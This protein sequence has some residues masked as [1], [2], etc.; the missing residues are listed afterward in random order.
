VSLISLGCAKNLIN[1]EQMLAM[2]SSSGFTITS[3]TYRADIAVINTCGFIEAAKKE[4]IDTILECAELKKKGILRHIIVAGCLAERY[5]DEIRS[6]LPEVDAILGIGN[7]G[8]ITDTIQELLSEKPPEMA[9]TKRTESLLF[10]LSAARKSP[11][12]FN[13]NLPRLVTTPKSWAYLKIAE[14]CDNRC[15]FC[16]IP[17]IRGRY[18]SR[19]LDDIIAEAEVL[20]ENGARELILVAQDTTRYGIDKYSKLML[21]E[22]TRRLSAIQNL[23]WLRLHYLYPDEITDELITEFA[24]NPKLLN[25]FDIP[26]QHIND[27]ILRRMRRRGSASEIKELFRKIRKTIPDAVLRTSL[28]SGL[29]GEGHSEFE[30]LCDFVREFRIERAGVFTFSPEEGTDAE[31]MPRPTAMEA[32][33]RKEILEEIQLEN[34]RLFNE[35]RKKSIITVLIEEQS[36][37]GFLARSYAESPEIDGYIRVTDE[38]LRIGSFYDIIIESISGDEAFGKI[39]GKSEYC[40]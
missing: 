40:Q 32:E 12:Y 9:N 37:N 29:P 31:K 20:V 8:D 22:L 7:F 13:D 21:P 25:Y 14:G 33:R 24:E 16:V 28:I 36:E 34:I 27:D 19:E 26:L 39:R 10:P 4:A 11:T 38:N 23:K 35:D 2:L 18:R 5:N 6:E 30:E 1:S 15:A 3:E 17:S